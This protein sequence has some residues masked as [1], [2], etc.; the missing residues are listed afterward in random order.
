MP[1]DTDSCGINLMK[2]AAMGIFIEFQQFCYRSIGRL[3][4]TS[5]GIFVADGNKASGCQ[6]LKQSRISAGRNS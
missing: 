5:A 2:E 6:M 3:S 4:C 1:R